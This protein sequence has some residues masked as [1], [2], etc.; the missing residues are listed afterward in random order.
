MSSTVAQQHQRVGRLSVCRDG[1]VSQARQPYFPASERKKRRKTGKC[2]CIF[3]FAFSVFLR[4][5]PFPRQ[6]K[7]GWLARLGIIGNLG[8]GMVII[9]L[10]PGR[11][12]LSF[13]SFPSLPVSTE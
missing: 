6:K 8:D 3:P 12:S 10:L 9:T 5:F 7:Y 13:H 2:E 1:V 11:K 4:F